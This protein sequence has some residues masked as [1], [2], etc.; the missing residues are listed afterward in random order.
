MAINVEFFEDGIALVGD[1]SSV[2]VLRKSHYG[3]SEGAV[4]YL[5]PEEVLY[6]MDI[7]NANCVDESGKS[8]SF[9]EVSSFYAKRVPRMMTRYYAYKDWRDRG[10]V[11]KSNTDDKTYHRAP[12]HEYPSPGFDVPKYKGKGVFYWDDNI[13]VIDDNEIAK[14]M[15]SEYW[16]GQYATYKALQQGQYGKLDLYETIFLAKHGSISLKNVS[17]LED[18]F[19]NAEK[20]NPFFRAIY[21]VYEDWRL[22][23]YVVK[24]GFKFGTHFRIYFPGAS[25]ALDDN[26]WIHSKHLL[27]VFPRDMELL[28]AELS[29]AIR[30]AHSVRKTFILAIP[31]EGRDVKRVLSDFVLYHRKRGVNETPNTGNPSYLMLAL[32]EEEKISGEYLA[33][34]ISYA[35]DR[36]LNL[37]LAIVDRETS[38]TYYRVKRI[39]LKDSRYEYYEIDWIQP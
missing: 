8:L 23:G 32:H 10:L 1:Q 34:A 29:R 24:T 25:P 13:T 38:V 12:V 33:G 4:I 21:N 5:S 18:L 7:R 37:L 36:G 20:D 11:V 27:H 39:D 6:L 9:N 16:F 35:A 28:T 2:S 31:G 22:R 30:V 15:Y 3:R 26:E 14:K 17:D 19:K